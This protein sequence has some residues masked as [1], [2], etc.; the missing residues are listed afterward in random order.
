[1]DASIIDED[2]LLA[3]DA[4]DVPLTEAEAEAELEEIVELL[5]Y[6][7]EENQDE[8]I[9]EINEMLD[10]GT[11]PRTIKSLLGEV[12]MGAAEESIDT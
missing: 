3:Q 1:M 10:E 9:D 2:V 6:I 8:F 7:P 5:E 4:D 11:S 12:I